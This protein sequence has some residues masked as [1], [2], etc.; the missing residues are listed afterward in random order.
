MAYDFKQLKVSIEEAK[1][2]LEREYFSIRTGRATPALLDTVVVEAYGSRLPINQV[3]AVGVEDARTLRI[4]P[5]DVSQNKEIERGIVA[6]DLG[7]SVS[8]DERG[9]R[10]SFPELT[11]ERRAQFLKLVNQKLEDARVSIRKG[12]DLTWDDIQNKTREKSMSEDDKFKAKEDMQKMVDAGNG[13]IEALAE[14]KR[15]E[16][17]K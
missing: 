9:L 6:S 1:I 3:A 10:V 16:I 2:W 8:T 15:V 12:R 7:V 5:F 11:S 14:K 17:S 4:T 13:S